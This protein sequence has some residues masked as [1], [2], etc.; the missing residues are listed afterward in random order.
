MLRPLA[1]AIGML[2]AMIPV[3][4]AAQRLDRTSDG[5]TM[6][7]SKK[8]DEAI[9]SHPMELLAHPPL[10]THCGFNHQNLNGSNL[11]IAAHRMLATDGLS[12]P[13]DLERRRGMLTLTRA[14]P[15]VLWH[16]CRAVTRL[17]ERYD[18][19][20]PALRA[21]PYFTEFVQFRTAQSAALPLV[22]Q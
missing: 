7:L 10:T 6:R 5:S 21:N 11:S 18:I 8:D 17:R 9:M 16:R 3:H 2:A 19:F 14:P 4:A 1:I 20:P 22:K 15:M 13:L 12:L